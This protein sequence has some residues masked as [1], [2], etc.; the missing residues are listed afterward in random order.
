MSHDPSASGRLPVTLPNSPHRHRR[1]GAAPRPGD[2]EA[3]RWDA[4]SKDRAQPNQN[5]ADRRTP[6]GIRSRVSILSVCSGVQPVRS[7][8]EPSDVS[9]G[10]SSHWTGRSGPY[11]AVLGHPLA[12]CWQPPAERHHLRVL[13][14]PRG[15]WWEPRR[16]DCGRHVRAPRDQEG[17]RP[18][19]SSRRQHANGW[20]TLVMTLREGVWSSR[21]PLS[22]PHRSAGDGAAGRARR[23]LASATPGPVDA[24]SRSGLHPDVGCGGGGR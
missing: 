17:P 3:Q 19:R 12:G 22:T 11:R 13:T 9:A 20:A 14:A 21:S 18:C 1:I 15:C 8:V 10:Q 2:H 7:S 4:G 5:G 6:N 24:G 23:R 16:P